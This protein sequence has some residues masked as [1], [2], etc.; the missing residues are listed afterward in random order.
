MLLRIAF[1]QIRNVK[2]N[3]VDSTILAID[4]LVH[5]EAL[6][7][8][9]F[10]HSLIWLIPILELCHYCQA[11][12]NV[13]RIG[14]RISWCLDLAGSSNAVLG[15]KTPHGGDHKNYESKT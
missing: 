2:G 4:E 13:I 8:R 5:L 15:G 3:F 12:R 10:G 1:D 6:V 14:N 7:I 9:G 11:Q